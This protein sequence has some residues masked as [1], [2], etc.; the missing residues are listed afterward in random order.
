MTDVKYQEQC[1]KFCH[2]TGNNNNYFAHTWQKFTVS[3]CFL[4]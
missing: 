1:S 3:K 4:V 2:T